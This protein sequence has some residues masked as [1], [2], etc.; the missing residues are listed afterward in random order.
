MLKAG[1]TA[2]GSYAAVREL[3]VLLAPTQPRN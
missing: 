2:Q 3:G 1:W